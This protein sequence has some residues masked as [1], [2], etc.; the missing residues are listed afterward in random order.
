MDSR[1]DKLEAAQA[2]LRTDFDNL[3]SSVVILE[4]AVGSQLL[5]EGHALII[6]KLNQV[7]GKPPI[8]ERLDNLEYTVSLHD[9]A[10]KQLLQ[11]KA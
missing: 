1:L 10:L 6:E 3:F 5:I 4:G 7:M 9:D 8:E 2:N 11:D